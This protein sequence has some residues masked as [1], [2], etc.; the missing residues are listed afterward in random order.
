VGSHA[1]SWQSIGRRSKVF[2]S[3][4]TLLIGVMSC[5]GIGPLPLETAA[6]TILR[7]GTLRGLEFFRDTRPLNKG[8]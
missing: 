1:A 6:A 4:S 7:N 3:L 5:S 2:N 8:V